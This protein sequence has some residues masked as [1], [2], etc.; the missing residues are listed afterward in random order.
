M[1]R[2]LINHE[3]Y[4]Y[5]CKCKNNLETNQ[6]ENHEFVLLEPRYDNFKRMKLKLTGINEINITNDALIFCGHS[7]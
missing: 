3:W 4:Q 5:P 1:S 2:H 6:K 7:G